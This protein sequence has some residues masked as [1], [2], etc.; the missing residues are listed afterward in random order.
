MS[1]PYPKTVA[2]IEAWGI[3]ANE[4]MVEGFDLDGYY[5]FVFDESGK[6]VY[7]QG[8][9]RYMTQRHS[10]PDNCDSALIV[11]QFRAEGGHVA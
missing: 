4:I 6:R 3:N 5:T 10:W 2:M 11:N 9:Q 7:L 8:A 1:S